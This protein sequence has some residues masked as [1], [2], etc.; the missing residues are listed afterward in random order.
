MWWW[1]HFSKCGTFIPVLA[2]SMIDETVKFFK[3]LLKYEGV[4][5]VIVSNKDAIKIQFTRIFWTKLFV[6]RAKLFFKLPP[7]DGASKYIARALTM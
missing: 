3:N 2:A 4:P 5:Q 1:I 7:L 6:D